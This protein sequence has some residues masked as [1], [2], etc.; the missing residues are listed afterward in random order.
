MSPQVHF[1]LSAH[2]LQH[3]ILRPLRQSAVILDQF[4][5]DRTPVG[6][7]AARGWRGGW[8]QF[9]FVSSYPD[10]GVLYDILPQ[11]QEEL[12]GVNHL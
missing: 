1:N 11:F 5:K 6:F 7:G 12:S 9:I 10:A 2:V 4:V 8:H 3:H